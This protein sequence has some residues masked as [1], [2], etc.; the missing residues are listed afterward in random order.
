MFLVML[1]WLVLCLWDCLLQAATEALHCEFKWTIFGIKSKFLKIYKCIIY[2]PIRNPWYSTFATFF[3]FLCRSLWIRSENWSCWWSYS[4]KA[5]LLHIP[6]LAAWFKYFKSL[7]CILWTDSSI[8]AAS[9]IVQR[10]FSFQL[11]TIRL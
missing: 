1:F 3:K 10:F 8:I 5:F 9:L 2:F 4:Q 7:I 6:S 11:A